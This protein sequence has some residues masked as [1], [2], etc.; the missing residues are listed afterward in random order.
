[1]LAIFKITVLTFQIYKKKE[2]NQITYFLSNFS[3]IPSREHIKIRLQSTCSHTCFISIKCFCL[4]KQD[5][6]LQCSILDPSLLRDIGN[7]TLKDTGK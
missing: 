6:A 3:L 4:I 2:K 5:I 7:T 1:M